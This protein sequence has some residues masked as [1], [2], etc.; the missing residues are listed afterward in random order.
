MS[1][2][3]VITEVTGA[4]LPFDYCNLV[5]LFISFGLNDR[6]GERFL[7]EIGLRE[8]L[9]FHRR[10]QYVWWREKIAVVQLWS[11]FGWDMSER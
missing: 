9:T 8:P 1:P 10:N 6:F 7:D 4:L 11:F 2:L 3:E 5:L